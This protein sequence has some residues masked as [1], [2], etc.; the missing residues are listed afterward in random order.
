MSK[1]I[2]LSS[3]KR[4]KTGRLQDVMKKLRLSSH[5]MGPPCHCKRLKCFD[6]LNDL[7]RNSILSDFNNM[8]SID[9]QNS[10]LC[11]LISVV[12]VQRRRSRLPERTASYHQSSFIYKI[13]VRRDGNIKEMC[14][15]SKAFISI[16]GITK[17]KLEHLQISLKQNGLTP[18]DMR[19]KHSA[20]SNKLSDALYNKVYEHIKSFKGRL[21]HYS[22]KK[23]KKLYLPESFNIKKM[24]LI[25]KQLYPNEKVS[26]ETYRMVFNTKFNIS[27]GYPHS[28]TY[29]VCDNFTAERNKLNMQRHHEAEIKRLEVEHEL[30]KRKA[31]WFYDRKKEAKIRART[32]QDFAAIALDFQKNVS[33]PNVST[34]DV[35]YC[36]QLSMYSFNIHVLASGRSFFYSYPEHVARKGSNE[37]IS[38]L[39]DFIINHLDND[40]RSLHIFCD[41]AGGQTKN[42]TMFRFM[43]FVVHQVK[44][45][46]YIQITFPIRG[47]SYLLCDKNMGLIN[48]KTRM[49]LPDDWYELIRGSRKNPFP[50]TVI[51]VEQ[52]MVRNWNQFLQPEFT[53]KCLFAIQPV[54]EI[55]CKKENCRLITYRTSYNGHWLQSPITKANKNKPQHLQLAENEFRLPSVSYSGKN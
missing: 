53:P 41:S 39:F 7:E 23:S 45:L 40:V 29:S 26:Y 28:D 5:E 55:F 48:L 10:Y 35:Y 15:C 3:K 46:D 21:S 2:V 54:R 25:F 32:N 8:T 38:F 19:G 31:Q 34:N 50:F 51:E 16:H 37:V 43:H 13:R 14:V 27:F 18:K 52:N 1:N 22:L 47:H 36:R 24:F 33:L 30:H 17:G 44:R 49:E 9:E 11:G 4:Q 6:V 20:L 42:I 12:P